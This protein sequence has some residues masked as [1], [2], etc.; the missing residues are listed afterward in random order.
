MRYFFVLSI[1]LTIVLCV[2]TAEYNWG[3][4]GS[5]DKLLAK[6]KVTNG[7]TF[8]LAKTKKYVFQQK[9]TDASTITAIKVTDRSSKYDSTA[10]LVSGGPGSK[11]C[12]IKI[13]SKRG[14]KIKSRVEIWGR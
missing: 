14:K 11:G 10:E 4:K 1:I 2:Y 13:K 9:K 3:E 5:K 8:G 6:D 7:A 12:T